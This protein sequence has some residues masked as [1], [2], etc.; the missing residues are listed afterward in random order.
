M[1]LKEKSCVP[2]EGGVDPLLKSEVSDYLGKLEEGW[3]TPDFKVIRKNYPFKNFKEGMKFV[4]RIAEIAEQENHHP[5]VCIH[6]SNVDVE[7]STH[8]IG[9][10][11]ENDFILAAK[12]DD[13]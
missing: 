5:D 3:K 11:S 9:G 8:A 12:I 10:L 7:L 6:Y 13:L 2:C 4:N 1:E